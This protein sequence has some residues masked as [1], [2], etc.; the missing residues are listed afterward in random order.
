MKAHDRAN[1]LVLECMYRVDLYNFKGAKGNTLQV[2]LFPAA[3]EQ[4][5]SYYFLDFTDGYRYFV[6]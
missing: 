1:N 3:A 6:L 5:F 4:K 2:L